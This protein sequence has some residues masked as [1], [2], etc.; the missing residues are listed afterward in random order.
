MT[1][2]TRVPGVFVTG[3]D[4]GIGKTLVS[5]ALA[6]WCR[7]LGLRVGVMK[8]VATGGYDD[9]RRLMRAAGSREP[10]SLVNP[11]NF[12]EPMAP[13]IAARRAGRT[14]RLE[15]V[16]RAFRTLSA[17]HDVMI[18]E[19][20]GGLLVPLTERVTVADLA[21]RLGLPL[22]VVARAGLG[23]INHTVLTCRWAHQQRLPVCGVVLNQADRRP[24]E[25]MARLVI[26]TNP[27]ALR[28]LTQ[29]PVMGPLPHLSAASRQS[30]GALA[31]W[32][33]A[34]VGKASL[35][36]LLVCAKVTPQ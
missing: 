10:V 35:T 27:P 5:C 14:V 26:Q 22:V 4:T 6:A 25:H 24:L 23:T 17:R 2:T 12:H 29:M 21:Q 13:W 11:L 8:P 30:P 20:V 36:R 3:T 19:G 9:A 15:A 31:D 34:G 28:R 33:E 1:R 32:L 7:R 18:V 16:T